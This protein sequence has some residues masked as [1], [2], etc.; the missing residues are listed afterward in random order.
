MLSSL[1]FPDSLKSCF[2]CCPPIRPEGYDHLDHKNIIRKMLLENSRDYDPDD[3]DVRPVTGYSCW[4]MGFID[5][6]NRQAGCLLHPCQ[7][8]GKDLRYR[9][10]YGNKC[11][12]EG[13]QEAG[14]FER[15]NDA[16][17]IFW[18][19]LAEGMDS[20]E[21]SSRKNN[22]L[23]TMLKWGNTLLSAI[24]SEDSGRHFNRSGFL[25]AYP[26][27]ITDI[28]PKGHAYLLTNVVIETGASVLKNR[29]F[30]EAFENFSTGLMPEIKE[31]FY[32]GDGPVFVHAM[33]LDSLFADFLRVF[34]KIRKSDTSTVEKI[35][36]YTD[37]RLRLF[38][39]GIK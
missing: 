1:C 8:N 3:G 2:G 10:D 34:L 7:S 5:S 38:S 22:V 25:D 19:N 11:L 26:F 15:L 16:E 31:R 30:K 18:L 12:R 35:R 33:N 20:F 24:A 23:F 27:F 37:N 13:C 28:S 21:Y 39:E 4:A 14:T 6:R 17:K 36:R 29:E 9:I 32:M